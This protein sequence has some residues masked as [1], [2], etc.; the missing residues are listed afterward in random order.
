[1]LGGL[2]NHLFRRRNGCLRTHCPERAMI[3]STCQYLPRNEN[4]FVGAGVKRP[5]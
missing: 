2:Q 1:M 3:P 5:S 4:P